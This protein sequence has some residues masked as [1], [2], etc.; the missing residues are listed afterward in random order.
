MA[1]NRAIFRSTFGLELEEVFE[2]FEVNP[3]A[4]GTVAQVHRAALRPAFSHSA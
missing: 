4:S 2:W 1:H 3:I